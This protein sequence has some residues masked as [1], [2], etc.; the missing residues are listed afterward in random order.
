MPPEKISVL[1]FRPDVK[2]KKKGNNVTTAIT[3]RIT[4]AS[5]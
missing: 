2:A 4:T 1:F 5:P 3:S